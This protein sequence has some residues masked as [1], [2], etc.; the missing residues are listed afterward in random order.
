MSTFAGYECA[1]ATVIGDFIVQTVPAIGGL[2]T[3]DFSDPMMP[4]EAGRIEF[5][6]GLH[7]HWIASSTDGR[8][9]VVSGY[10]ALAGRLLIVDL[11]P[12]SGRMTLDERFS[13]EGSIFP[14]VSF[15]RDHWPHGNYPGRDSAWCRF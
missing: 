12:I 6:P 3:I 1:L 13:D 5:G 4:R 9:I 14:G 7:P 15:R 10:R 8:R 11:D 2:V